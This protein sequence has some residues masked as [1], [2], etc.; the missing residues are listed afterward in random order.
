MTRRK[1]FTFWL[2][3][4]VGSLIN[5][6]TAFGS[7]MGLLLVP[8][9]GR[10][11]MEYYYVALFMVSPFLLLAIFWKFIANMN[12]VAF[13]LVLIIFVVSAG[14]YLVCH[15]VHGHP[16]PT[17]FLMIAIVLELIAIPAVYLLLYLVGAFRGISLKR[18]RGLRA[19]LLSGED[20]PF[21]PKAPPHD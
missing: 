21:R 16:D 2:L 14:F 12:H 7:E 3:V 1:V 18:K 9:W 17:L 10:V 15:D 4:I 13:P 11:T 6:L 19:K 8:F 20:D 5:L